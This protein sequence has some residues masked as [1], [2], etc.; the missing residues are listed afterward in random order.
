MSTAQVVGTL[1]VLALAITPAAAAQRLSAA[2]LTVAALSVIFAL[3]AADGGLLASFQASEV[4]ASVFITSISFGI[5]LAA[6]LAG[7]LL[8][9]RRR[10]QR[11]TRRGRPAGLAVQDHAARPAST[12]APSGTDGTAS[13]AGPRARERRER[14]GGRARVGRR[15]GPGGGQD[16][17]RRSSRSPPGRTEVPSPAG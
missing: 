6:R 13:E 17:G 3:I 16:G 2:P 14:P 11:E 5:Y 12:G 9:D 10:R 8:R 1:L 4:K 7:P 15:A